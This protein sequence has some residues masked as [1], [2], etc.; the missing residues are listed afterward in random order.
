MYAPHKL[1]GAS[2]GAG[3]GD[4]ETPLPQPGPFRSPGPAARTPAGWWRGWGPVR[5]AGGGGAREAGE[6]E[7]LPAAGRDCWGRLGRLVSAFEEKG[8]KRQVESLN[9][10]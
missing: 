6:G 3:L 7:A 5:E 10:N 9:F 8:E 1:S 4:D 2:L